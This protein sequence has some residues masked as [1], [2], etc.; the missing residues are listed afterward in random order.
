MFDKYDIDLVKVGGARFEVSTP[1]RKIIF[2]RH[3]SGL[4][5]HH[6]NHEDFVATQAGFGN[7]HKMTQVCCVDTVMDKALLYS[8]RELIGAKKAR[9]LYQTIGRPGLQDFKR[10]VR[11]NQFG[12]N[13]TIKDINIAEDV[14]GKD[15]G[16]LKGTMVLGTPRATNLTSDA[17]PDEIMRKHCR[18]IVSGDIMFIM[19]VPFF[20]TYSIDI[21]FMTCEALDTREL[22][23]IKK[24]LNKVHSIYVKRGFVVATYVMDNKF[25]PLRDYI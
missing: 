17:V 7:D 2:K 12:N 18:L 6:T 25:E 1:K 16:K 3:E 20:V 10:L 8:K 9:K 4:Y 13:I 19:R 15:V 24:A 5:Y 23:N 11:Q 21:N 22:S 14:F